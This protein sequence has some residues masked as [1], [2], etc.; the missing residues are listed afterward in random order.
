MK[1]EREVEERFIGTGTKLGGDGI[2][3]QKVAGN[4]AK[5][6]PKDIRLVLWKEGFTLD[7]EPL[8]RF[9]D[10]ANKR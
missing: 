4:S 10:P 5:E 1:R 8:R 2:E 9:D 6:P 3:S 7:D